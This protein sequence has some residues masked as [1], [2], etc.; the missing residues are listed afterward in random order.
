MNQRNF[1]LGLVTLVKLMKGET[2]QPMHYDADV[3]GDNNIINKRGD[4]D[5]VITANWALDDF[6]KKNG[7][8][9]IIPKSHL[10]GFNLKGKQLDGI[11]AE[12]KAGSVVL[13]LG[14]TYH[15]GAA[16]ISNNPRRSLLV[17]YNNGYLRQLENLTLAIN[18]DVVQKC[19]PVIQSLMGFSMVAPYFG[20]VNAKS[21][22]KLLEN[23]KDVTRSVDDKFKI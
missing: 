23:R 8:T 13:W 7:A 22:M 18:R 12:M 17:A 4:T 20:S 21:P 3:F 10:W 16:N 14:R 1:L 11:Q 5:I 6:T 9:R 15:S 2:M 19:S